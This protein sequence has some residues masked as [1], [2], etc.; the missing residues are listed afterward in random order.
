MIKNKPDARRF[1]DFDIVSKM[2]KGAGFTLIEL[3][4]V[5]T[6]I[7]ILMVI[8]IPAYLNYRVRSQISEGFM[9]VEPVR[10]GMTE[11]Y[12]TYG[13]WPANN[14][15]AGV[16]DLPALFVSGIEGDYVQS[17]DIYQD[18]TD[19]DDL[20]SYILIFYSTAEMP[21]LRSAFNLITFKPTAVA[22][23][24]SIE[25]D[26]RPSVSVGKFWNQYEVK[27]KYRPSRCRD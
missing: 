27:Q 17:V 1:F 5:L 19:P 15:E 13:R 21:E 24:G 16:S 10:V 14:Q 9:L 12:T 6:I 25:W 8:A 3:M 23:G 22:D 20:Q 18:V 7:S 4:I 26:C 11:F 2:R